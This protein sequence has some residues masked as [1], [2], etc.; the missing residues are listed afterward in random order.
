MVLLVVSAG[1][2]HIT[3][4]TEECRIA[5]LACR[6]H[7][8]TAAQLRQRCVALVILPAQMRC[9][10]SIARCRYIAGLTEQMSAA[11]RPVDS[12]M[13]LCETLCRS[14]KHVSHRDCPLHA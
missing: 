7:G 14:C 13:T 8:A 11:V 1:R 6:G 9:Q 10:L 4:V 3:D 2:L 5:R 12:Q